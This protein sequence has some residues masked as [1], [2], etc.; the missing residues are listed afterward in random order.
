MAGNGGRALRSRGEP[1]SLEARRRAEGILRDMEKGVTPGQRRA[2]RAAEVLEWIATKEARAGLLE[3]TKGA[4]DARLTREAA[5][6]C[7]RLAGRN[8]SAPDGPFHRGE[9]QGDSGCLEEPSRRGWPT[10][11]SRCQ[12][13]ILPKPSLFLLDL[14]PASFTIA[15]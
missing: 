7:K 10:T 9:G 1:P 15:P 5:A 2:L 3:L 8:S 13:N 14:A 12:V 4:P 11:S 6:A